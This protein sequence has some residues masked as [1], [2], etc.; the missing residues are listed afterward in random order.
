[1]KFGPLMR[2]PTPGTVAPIWSEKFYFSFREIGGFFYYFA[3]FCRNKLHNNFNFIFL[4]FKS[5]G[6]G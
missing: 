2:S 5:S 6:T 1:M 4:L 3:D